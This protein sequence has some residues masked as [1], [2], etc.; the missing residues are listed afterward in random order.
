MLNGYTGGGW[1][2][3]GTSLLPPCTTTGDSVG[4]SAVGVSAGND[5]GDGGL[6]DKL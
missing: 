4:A 2:G 5:G 6:M 3:G 1:Y